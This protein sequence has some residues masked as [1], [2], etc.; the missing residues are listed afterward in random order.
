MTKNSMRFILRLSHNQSLFVSFHNSRFA[1]AKMQ[2][3]VEAGRKRC[4]CDRGKKEN[5]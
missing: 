1:Y 3:E 4:V 5:K 2:E